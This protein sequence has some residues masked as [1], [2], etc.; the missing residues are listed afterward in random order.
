MILR[1]LSFAT[2]PSRQ[3]TRGAPKRRPAVPQVVFIPHIANLL[4]FFS[5]FLFFLSP[6]LPATALPAPYRHTF[7]TIT[8]VYPL[9]GQG[10]L[11]P[12]SS[13]V[14]PAKR[15]AIR[16]PYR[17]ESSPHSVQT[18]QQIFLRDIRLPARLVV[19]FGCTRS[20]LSLS[21]GD[22]TPSP[23]QPDTSR[24]NRISPDRLFLS[25]P[26]ACRATRSLISIGECRARRTWP[27]RA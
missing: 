19:R 23:Y 26:V 3:N 10:S 17:N 16:Q 2:H 20:S 5:S 1:G 24:V 27:L 9:R 25:Y 13:L 8:T 6:Y 15:R 22:L 7:L 12:P 14:S 18:P 11:P 4:R 21:I